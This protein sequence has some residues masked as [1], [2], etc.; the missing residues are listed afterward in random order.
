M[1]IHGNS[2]PAYSFAGWLI[3]DQIILFQRCFVNKFMGEGSTV[4]PAVPE[5]PPRVILTCFYNSGPSRTLA[6]ST[7]AAPLCCL[8][9]RLDGAKSR[10]LSFYSMLHICVLRKIIRNIENMETALEK[11]C[12]N[13]PI[14]QIHEGS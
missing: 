8:P 1:Q 10:S 7:A 14:C 2:L 9:C 6:S 5:T 13:K 4:N 12:V 11:S 3:S